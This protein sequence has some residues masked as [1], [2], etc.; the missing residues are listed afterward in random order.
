ME[1][2]AAFGTHEIDGNSLSIG[3]VQA[4]FNG[5]FAAC[6]VEVAGEV[7]GDEKD[8]VFFKNI[9]GEKRFTGVLSCSGAVVRRGNYLAFFGDPVTRHILEGNRQRPAGCILHVEV[10]VGGGG[11]SCIAAEGDDL[12]AGDAVAFFYFGAFGG[13]VKVMG[14]VAITVIDDNG[15][16]I[17]KKFFAGSA[18]L[19]ILFYPHNAACSAGADGIAFGYQE[20]PGVEIEAGVGVR[21]MVALYNLVGCAGGEGEF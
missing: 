21:A 8:G 3:L 4:A 14:V 19:P 18:G 6:A 10:Q 1:G 7:A 13:E 20:I 2:G 16:S 5:V 11:K 17:V 15:V 9:G 12:S